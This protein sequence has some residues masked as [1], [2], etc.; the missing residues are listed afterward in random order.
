MT[1]NLDIRPQRVW[2]RA[3]VPGKQMMTILRSHESSLRTR[4]L[5]GL[6]GDEAYIGILTA[7]LGLH[8][9]PR[10]A[11]PHGMPYGDI[12]ADIRD[13]V[14]LRFRIKGSAGL[15]ESADGD[16]DSAE[17]SVDVGDAAIVSYVVSRLGALSRQS[18][19]FETTRMTELL[20]SI[21]GVRDLL[22]HVAGRMSH[23]DEEQ[24]TALEALFVGPR[25]S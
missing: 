4:G 3:S 15:A 12:L 8:L 6:Y 16:E 18:T 23:K 19:V 17:P 25:G 10:H 21:R 9:M 7:A 11:A 14:Q 22:R 1:P 2:F 24:F 20:G 13:F 5:R